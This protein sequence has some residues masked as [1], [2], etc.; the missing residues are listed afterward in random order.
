MPPWNCS[1]LTCFF[2]SRVNRVNLLV[3]QLSLNLAFLLLVPI[4]LQLSPMISEYVLQIPLQD[5]R[6]R[7]NRCL[8]LSPIS[9]IKR[10]YLSC[11]S[12]QQSH[13][14]YSYQSAL[15]Q[16]QPPPIP[17]PTAVHQP[18][19]VP[20]SVGDYY[21]FCTV[22]RHGTPINVTKPIPDTFKCSNCGFACTLDK[23]L[24]SYYVCD[25]WKNDV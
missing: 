12:A 11:L 24:L 22:C 23:H 2:K 16:L 19:K 9:S 5:T 18:P 20:A 15:P 17:P 14:P 8:L 7:F 13:Y 25:E 4:Q 21:V 10:N 6:S 1:L 3:R